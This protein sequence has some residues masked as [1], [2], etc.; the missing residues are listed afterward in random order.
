MTNKKLWAAALLLSGAA[1]G[2]LAA[3]TTI[4]AFA[5]LSEVAFTAPKDNV[6]R[7]VSQ[8]PSPADRLFQS[9][10]IE[11]KIAEIKALLK[12]PYLA[13]MFENCFP[14]TLDTTVHFRLLDGKPDT[15]SIRA[16]STPC[17]CATRAHKSGPTCS[18]PTKIPS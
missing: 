7:Y 11:K 9:D 14:N 6:G 18:S 5:P 10:I 1:S 12:N 4:H 15:L 17:G 16:T 13:W 8:R 2:T 3:E